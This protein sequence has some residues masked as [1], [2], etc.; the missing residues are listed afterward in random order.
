MRTPANIAGYPIHPMLV[1]IPIGL[2]VF[3]LVCDFIAMRSG[4]PELWTGIAYWTLIGGIVGALAAALPGLID[5]LS[6]EDPAIKKTALTHMGINLAVV[7]LYVL[8]GVL[9]YRDPQGIG[10]VPF[11]LSVLAILML[12]VSGWLGGK[13]VYLARVGV[14]DAP[15]STVR[16][17]A[18]EFRNR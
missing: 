6:L 8:N 5:L 16:A 4:T 9:R 1:A 11:A 2:W 10:G 17:K 15:E 12:L 18:P 13:M 7:A 3:S 14:T